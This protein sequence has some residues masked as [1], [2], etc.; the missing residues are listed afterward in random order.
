MAKPET[1]KHDKRKN[2]F[3]DGK[4][5]VMSENV[6]MVIL[7]DESLTANCVCFDVENGVIRQKKKGFDYRILA[8]QANLEPNLYYVAIKALNIIVFVLL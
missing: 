7:I 6:I 5:A 3:R 4:I 2:I 1:I 8:S